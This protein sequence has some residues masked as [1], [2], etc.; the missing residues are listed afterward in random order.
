MKVE[1]EV[2]R[3]LDTLQKTRTMDIL[4]TI[5]EGDKKYTE[6]YNHLVVVDR[7][8]TMTTL[9]HR[10]DELQEVGLIST[11]IYDADRGYVKY[12]LTPFGSFIAERLKVL[13]GE[14]EVGLKKSQISID[15]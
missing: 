5:A 12:M 7:L 2:R 8:I 15:N 3:V 9:K 11:Q 10:L 13:Y 1:E 14:I 4:L 6:I